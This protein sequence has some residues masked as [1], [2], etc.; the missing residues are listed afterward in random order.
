MA[1]LYRR[2]S[3]EEFTEDDRMKYKT[4]HPIVITWTGWGNG[5]FGEEGFIM[6][7]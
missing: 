6:S 3:P 1:G 7:L 5:E 4:I 2:I